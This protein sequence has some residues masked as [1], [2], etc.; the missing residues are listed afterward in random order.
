MIFY[1]FLYLAT[2]LV[3]TTIEFPSYDIYRDVYEVLEEDCP[4]ER[5]AYAASSAFIIFVV[6]VAIWPYVAF[7]S[8]QQY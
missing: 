6:L 4:R 2:G 5:R 3:F 8:L 1:L 7:K